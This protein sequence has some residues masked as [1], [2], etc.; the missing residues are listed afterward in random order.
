MRIIIDL[1]EI[2]QLEK[3]YNDSIDVVIK[4]PDKGYFTSGEHMF[5]P[6]GSFNYSSNEGRR[7]RFKE[8]RIRETLKDI[9]Y[10]KDILDIYERENYVRGKDFALYKLEC[11][12][13]RLRR[14]KED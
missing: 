4:I 2:D 10:Y 1:E 8:E 3:E 12:Y 7:N 11:L 9:K 14:L 6:L 13:D 5:E